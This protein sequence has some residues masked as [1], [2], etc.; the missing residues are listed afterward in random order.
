ML[1]CKCLKTQVLG[2]IVSICDLHHSYA[3]T[4]YALHDSAGNLI[5]AL[6]N[7]PGFTQHCT[8]WCPA[9]P[10]VITCHGQLVILSSPGAQWEYS[11][12]THWKVLEFWWSAWKVLNFFLILPWILWIFL[13]KCLKISILSL[14]NTISR[15]LWTTINWSH[16]NK[17]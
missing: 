9:C 1:L 10:L 16:S 8:I 5:C 7:F 12:S 13:E 2:S 14:K 17:I 15:Y 6:H 3:R 11:V 4:L